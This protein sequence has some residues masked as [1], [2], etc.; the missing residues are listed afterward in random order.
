[1]GDQTCATTI[2]LLRRMDRDTWTRC[3]ASAYDWGIPAESRNRCVE[4]GTVSQGRSDGKAACEAT[5]EGV[6][7]AR[8]VS[9]GH[10]GAHA[11]QCD[12]GHAGRWRVAAKGQAEPCTRGEGS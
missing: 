6:S 9:P 12:R 7:G 5:D 8:A 11:G 2:P 3:D 10:L 1:M 4:H